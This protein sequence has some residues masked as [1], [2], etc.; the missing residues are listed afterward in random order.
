L[1]G[2]GIPIVYYGTEQGYAGGYDPDNRET[3]WTDLN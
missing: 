2:K 3:L 1:F